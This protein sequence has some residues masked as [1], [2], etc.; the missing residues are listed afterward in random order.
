MDVISLGRCYS[1]PKLRQRGMYAEAFQ[2]AG[3]K[4]RQ[5]ASFPFL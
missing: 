1:I 4:I 3:L 2:D 5:F